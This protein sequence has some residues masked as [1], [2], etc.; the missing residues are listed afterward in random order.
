MYI[1]ISASTGSASQKG[2]MEFENKEKVKVYIYDTEAKLLPYFW[3][4]YF[5]Y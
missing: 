2:S 4:S 5:K 3:V 1:F